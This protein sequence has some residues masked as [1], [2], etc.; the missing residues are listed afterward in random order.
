MTN[1]IDLKGRV[2]VVT[3][4]AQGIGR[5]IVERLLACGAA[6]AVWDRDFKSASRCSAELSAG[7]IIPVACDIRFLSAVESARE[8]DHPHIRAHRIACKQCRH[9]GAECG[10]MAIPMRCLERGAG[11]QPH[12][13]LSLLPGGNSEDDCTKLWSHRQCSLDC[14]KGGQSECQRLFSIEGRR[15]SAHQIA[16]KGTRRLRHNR[17]LHYSGG[18]TYGSV[19]SDDAA[20]HRVHAL[21][22]SKRPFCY[23][24]GD[25]LSCSFLLFGGMLIHDR[26]CVRHIRGSSN[27][28]KPIA[29]APGQVTIDLQIFVR[30]GRERI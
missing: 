19:R 16:W 18:C 6:V 12:R 8:L 23:C 10:H 11:N 28:L 26:C 20:T 9:S 14:W 7:S 21:E 4:G 27:I 2:A 24:G 29:C 25:C 30:V 3:G 15:H 22:N 13:H 17:K 5:A 1:Q